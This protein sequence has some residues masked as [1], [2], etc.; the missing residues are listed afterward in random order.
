MASR[1]ILHEFK[2]LNNDNSIVCLARAVDNEINTWNLAMQ[3]P[4]DTPYETGSFIIRVVFSADHPF[5]PPALQFQTRIYHPN[6]D[7]QGNICIDILKDNWSPV[8]SISKIVSSLQ[9][10]LAEPNPHDPLVQESAD[11][12]LDDRDEFNAK[13]KLWCNL[14]ASSSSLQA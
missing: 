12:Y 6:I 11:L 10:L 14:Y 7:S 4:V 8:L 3:G 1:R 9:S 13:A 5:S 2:E